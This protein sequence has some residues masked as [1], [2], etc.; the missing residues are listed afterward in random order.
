MAKRGG[1]IYIQNNLVNATELSALLPHFMQSRY[2]NFIIMRNVLLF[3]ILAAFSNGCTVVGFWSGT[4]IDKAKHYTIEN[5][6]IEN[7]DIE[8]GTPVSLTIKTAKSLDGRFSKIWQVDDTSSFNPPLI[9]NE[10]IDSSKVY[11]I[12]SSSSTSIITIHT[13]NR[14][15]SVP[16]YQIDAIEVKPYSYYILLTTGLG[17]MIDYAI[18]SSLDFKQ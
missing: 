2:T 17:M 18:F 12:K 3:I 10:C 6:T 14:R 1:F 5:P 9:Q 11:N 13:G 16:T 7:V 15:V 4:M 8:I